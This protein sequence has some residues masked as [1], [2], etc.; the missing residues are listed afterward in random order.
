[1]PRATQPA[2][3]VR[4]ARTTIVI[5]Q[6]AG[7]QVVGLEADDV[8]APA[9]DPALLEDLDG[10]EVRRPRRAADRDA[11]ARRSCLLAGPGAGSDPVGG[12]VRRVGLWRCDRAL[13]A[14][15]PEPCRAMVHP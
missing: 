13:P 12:D 14:Q 8:D 10:V 2:P 9:E 7:A 15:G 3:G 4:S 5:A 6:P 11:G 1:M